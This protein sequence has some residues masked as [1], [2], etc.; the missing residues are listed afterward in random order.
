MTW[1]LQFTGKCHFIGWNNL[2]VLHLFQIDIRSIFIK[3]TS[4]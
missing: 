2:Q 4:L 1:I 3:V